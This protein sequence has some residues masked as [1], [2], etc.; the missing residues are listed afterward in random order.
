MRETNISRIR[1]KF[2]VELTVYILEGTVGVGS[3]NLEGGDMSVSVDMNG[4]DVTNRVK[5]H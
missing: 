4:H 2:Y 3:D 1:K 5:E